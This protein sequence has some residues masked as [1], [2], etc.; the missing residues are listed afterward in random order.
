ML[1]KY[2]FMPKSY[3][4]KILSML[5]NSNDFKSYMCVCMWHILIF[6]GFWHMA[7]RIYICVAHGQVLK[8]NIYI[9]IYIYILL[10]LCQNP[11]NINF[12]DS[13]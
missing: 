7:N 10:A 1:E 3:L 11:L 5:Y 13:F 2:T 8:T 12:L 4:R 6:N 9:Y